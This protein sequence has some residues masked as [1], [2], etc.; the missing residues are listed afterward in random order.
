MAAELQ[1]RFGLTV[2]L[3]VGWLGYPARTLHDGCATTLP[4]TSPVGDR[5][6]ALSDLVVR[7]GGR[8]VGE[9]LARNLTA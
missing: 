4:P 5:R 6:R 2:K 9:V 8:M 7:S 1:A 3:R